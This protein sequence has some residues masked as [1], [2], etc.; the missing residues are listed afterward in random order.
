MIEIEVTTIKVFLITF[1]IAFISGMIIGSLIGYN[2]IAPHIVNQE[3]EDQIIEMYEPYITEL[4]IPFP[5]YAENFDIP[6]PC[7]SAPSG[8]K[9]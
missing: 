4:E 7:W 9:E 6:I 8:V 3:L 5:C 1:F 2:S